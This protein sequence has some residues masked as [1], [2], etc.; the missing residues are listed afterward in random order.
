MSSTSIQTDFHPP[1]SSLSLQTL[2]FVQDRIDFFL[3]TGRH[4]ASNVLPQFVSVE[5]LRHS[6]LMQSYRAAVEGFLNQRCNPDGEPM[7]HHVGNMRNRFGGMSF[8]IYAVRAVKQIIRKLGPY[9]QVPEAYKATFSQSFTGFDLDNETD[10]NPLA[11]EANEWYRQLQP[12][13]SGIVPQIGAFAALRNLLGPLIEALIIADRIL[14]L[15]E[16]GG[17]ALS[18]LRVIRLFSPDISPRSFALIATKH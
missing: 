6:L 18:S 14:F 17:A 4:L 2:Q 11:V 1:S 7:P 8:G 15:R 9:N 16:Q 13:R 5:D 3:D 12:T 10:T